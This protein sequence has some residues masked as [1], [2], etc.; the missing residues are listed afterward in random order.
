MQVSNLGIDGLEDIRQIGTGGSSRVYRARQVELDRIVAIKVLNPG[1]DQNVAKRF[2]RERKAMGRLSL[3]EGIVPVYTSGTTDHGEPYLVMPYYANGSLQDQ[4]DSGA[5]DWEAAVAFIDVAAETIAEAHDEGVVHLDLK[6]A[7]IL[8]TSAGA[9]RI[10]DFGIAKLTTGNAASAGTTGGAAFTPAYSAPETFLDGETGPP[11]DVY[12]LGAT[13]WALLV[14][15]PPFLTPGDDSNL[16]AVIGRVVNNPVGDLRHFTPA[17]I[18]DVIEQAMAKQPEDRYQ[19]AR[20]FSLAL[21]QAAAESAVELPPAEEPRRGTMFFPPTTGGA[22]GSP[23]APDTRI[24]T[25][26]DPADLPPVGVT[27]AAKAAAAAVPADAAARPLLQQTAQQTSAPIGAG[28]PAPAPILDLDRFRIGPILIGIAVFLGVV[29]VAFVALGRSSPSGTETAAEEAAVTVT[30]PAGPSLNDDDASTDPLDLGGAGDSDGASVS[31]TTTTDAPTTTEADEDEDDEAA[32]TTT[33]AGDDEDEEDDEP[34]T[35]EVDEDETTTT[36]EEVTTTTEAEEQTTTTE[37]EVTTTTE[38]QTTTTEEPTTTTE[39]PEPQPPT[40]LTAQVD[41]DEV[42]LSW[43]AP[44]NGPTPSTYRVYRNGSI[45]GQTGGATSFTD[46]GVPAGT[47]QYTV[48]SIADNRSSDDSAPQTVTV[49]DPTP[50][51]P[52]VTASGTPSSNSVELTFSADQ[53]FT[54][55]RLSAVPTGPGDAPLPVIKNLAPACETGAKDTILGLSPGTTYT[56]NV[57]VWSE[58]DVDGTRQLTITTGS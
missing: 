41:G 34:T 58:A 21:K 20:E 55:Y 5:L 6:P 51:P 54:R 7:N 36:E 4:I 40:G 56:I 30:I 13:L 19:T 44:A 18:C 49:A 31:A 25:R 43:S 2:D 16:M 57:K 26:I 15:H 39:A 9:P 23:P 8:L 52:V 47:H 24:Q 35:T 45:A 32:V 12:G 27:S 50:G 17:P 53:C 10:A 29:G 42:T 22:A 28:A 48:R 3:H 14:G 46:D 33:E 11:S 37:E 38:E 1:H